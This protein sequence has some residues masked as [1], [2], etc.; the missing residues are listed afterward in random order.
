MLFRRPLTNRILFV[1]NNDTYG[2]QS[3]LK[4]E[5]CGHVLADATSISGDRFRYD[6]DSTYDYDGSVVN[7]TDFSS[8]KLRLIYKSILY[9]YQNITYTNSI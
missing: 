8:L 4:I 7:G 3:Q 9:K 5:S 6:S 2:F 1:S